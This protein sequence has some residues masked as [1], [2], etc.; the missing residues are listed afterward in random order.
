MAD[1]IHTDAFPGMNNVDPD[2]AVRTILNMDV[3]AEGTEKKPGGP[4]EKRAGYSPWQSL[5]GAHSLWADADGSMFYCAAGVTSLE[6]LYRIDRNK[7]ITLLSAITGLGSPMFYQRVADRLF[8]SSASWCGVYQYGAIRSWGAEFSDDLAA[9]EDISGSEELMTHGVIS[10]PAMENLCLAGGRIFG[11]IGNRAYY[12]DPPFAYE[13]F[14]RDS[15]HEFAGNLTMIAATAFGLWFASADTTWF[16]SSLNP[17][18]FVFSVVGDGAVP[19]SLQY[20]NEFRQMNNVPVW[21]SKSGMQ[22]GMQGQV[23]PLTEQAVKFDV[24]GRAAS[25]QEQK[26]NGHYV[27]NMPLPD[28]GFGDAATCEVFRAG[29]LIR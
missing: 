17:S 14:R 21:I 11:S 24:A 7:T 4:V 10:A 27:A 2:A 5:V 22:A 20:L 3:I 15:F 8:I 9:F 26:L 25:Y 1:P 19:G 18:E 12:N 16:A 6:A 23:V 28:V 29:K 13:M